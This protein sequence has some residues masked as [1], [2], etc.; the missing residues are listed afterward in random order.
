M[1]ILFI[2]NAHMGQIQN[3]HHC[4]NALN[5]EFLNDLIKGGNEITSFQ[6]TMPGHNSSFTYGLEEHGIKCVP[7]KPKKNKL[8]SYIIAHLK[9]IP[10]IIKTDFVY[11]YYPNSFKYATFLC[12]LFRKKYGLYIRGMQGVDNSLSHKIYKKAY[13]IFTV[14][15]YFTNRVNEIVGR[16][17][18]HTI[19]PMI[20]YDDS[21]IVTDRVYKNKEKYTLLF[22]GRIVKDKGVVELL[23][24]IK[25]LN[26][27]QEYS[28]SLKM[29][30][31]G[32]F[33]DEAKELCKE[34]NIEHLVSFEGAV[35]DEDIKKAYYIGADAYILPTYH[36]GFPR[37][38]YEAMIFGTPIITTFVGGIPALMKNNENCLKIETKSI[39]SIVEK[40][41][42]LISNYSETANTLVANARE[43]VTPIISRK[44]LRHG[45]DLNK[46][47]GKLQQNH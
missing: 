4:T 45:E 46:K 37:T 34:L 41:N 12:R 18:A 42:D 11:I 31:Y 39:D 17:V 5:G 47:L 24:A 21:H 44:R 14:S 1:K 36:E 6:M 2:D 38:L 29:V 43:T 35:S 32:S 33:L 10:E 7:V 9:L 28:I 15:N 25:K 26:E 30:G 13:T 19:R 3:K 20:P 22:L 16:E 40:V 27:K 23:N 8:L